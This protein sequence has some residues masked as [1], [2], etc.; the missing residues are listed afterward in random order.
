MHLTL[1]RAERRRIHTTE[2]TKK[3]IAE[4]STIEDKVKAVNKVLQDG[5]PQNVSIDAYSGYTGYKPQF[6]V[7]AMNIVFKLGNWGFEEVASEIVTHQ[8]EK[9]TSTL[10]IAHVKVW[11]KGVDFQPASYGQSRVTKGDI[12][13][14]KKGA[15]TDAIKKALAYFSIGNRAYHGLLKAA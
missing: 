15:Q 4:A 8:T 12:G 9:G 1:D 7:D 2:Q 14:A 6:I 11:L 10:A 3:Q 5:E 13:D